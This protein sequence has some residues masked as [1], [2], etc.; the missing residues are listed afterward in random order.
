MKLLR[1]RISSAKRP[2]S[3]S[4]MMINYSALRC[5][6]NEVELTNQCRPPHTLALTTT[7]RQRRQ[8][9]YMQLKNVLNAVTSAML[10]A[11]HQVFVARFATSGNA[12]IHRLG[13]WIFTATLCVVLELAMLALPPG[14]P[15]VYTAWITAP[16]DATLSTVYKVSDA[17]SATRSIFGI[18]GLAYMQF[19]VKY[20]PHCELQ[21]RTKYK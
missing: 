15:S 3:S 7:S 12:G 2:F 18:Y 20:C 5:I 8:L 10:W 9:L 16:I 19:L 4:E 21:G 17:R 1:P 13:Q 14:A 6:Y 11:L